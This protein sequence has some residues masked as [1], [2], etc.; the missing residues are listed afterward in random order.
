MPDVFIS[1]NDYDNLGTIKLTEHT[2]NKT[3]VQFIDII[4]QQPEQLRVYNELLGDKQPLYDLVQLKYSSEYGMVY[5][6]PFIS[7]QLR[8]ISGAIYYPIKYAMGDNNKIVL[9]KILQKPQVIDEKVISDNHNIT[10]SFLFSHYFAQLMEKGENV[11]TNLLFYDFLKDTT[12]WVT[13]GN[14]DFHRTRA[15]L[16]GKYLELE[17]WYEV[18]YVEPK[19]DA[20]YGLSKETF[21]KTVDNVIKKSFGIRSGYELPT[22]FQHF[23][24]LSI[25]LHAIRFFTKAEYEDYEG[26]VTDFINNLQFEL[27]KIGFQAT[28]QY[29]YKIRQDPNASFGSDNDD[30]VATGGSSGGGGAGAS[31]GIYQSKI[32][33]NCDLIID[34]DT[35]KK[36]MKKW[37]DTL[38]TVKK[39]VIGNSVYNTFSDFTN[40]IK[41]NNSVEYGT[42]L[43]NFGTDSLRLDEIRTDND[44]NRVRVEVAPST[45]LTLHNHPNQTPPS[46]QDLRLTCKYANDP[47]LS[48]YRMSVIYN[49]KAETFYGVVITDRKTAA[50]LYKTL[51]TEIDNETNNFKKKGVYDKLLKKKRNVYKK[52][53]PEEIAIARLMIVVKAANAG[54]KI[55]KYE[56]AAIG[57]KNKI[58]V[59]DSDHEY[60]P[61][62]CN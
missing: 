42:G 8:K 62:K 4:N 39:A 27:L 55:V 57:N 23:C 14:T 37:I 59:Y 45:V 3:A 60:K 38:A 16:S 22:N 6:I 2:E 17:M 50:T 46:P 12:I 30:N 18:D 48:N 35:L 54:I 51:E 49:D 32:E 52:M 29:N 10:K 5:T 7:P 13:K 40:K 43:R 53:S 15:N 56:K 25:S 44:T 36:E 24:K 28:I 41:S 61:I 26:F 33:E 20:V 58:T 34:A 11:D 1:C 9:S 31:S 47:L 19:I 21:L